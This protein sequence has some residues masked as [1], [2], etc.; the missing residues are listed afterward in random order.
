MTTIKERKDI[1]ITDTWNLNDIFES[2]DLFHENFKKV[3]S[4]IPSFA[5]YVGKLTS[6]CELLYDF[7]SEQDELA[8]TMN[9]LYLYAHMH[10]HEDGNVSLY[11]DLSTKTETLSIEFYSAISFANPELS[12]LTE[13]MILDFIKENPKLSVYKRY[14]FEILR[15]KKHILNASTENLLAKV[16]EIASSPSQIF[17]MLDNVDINFGTVKNDDGVEVPL[18]HGNY[19]S[20]LESKTRSVRESAFKTLYK[21]YSSYKNTLATTFSS[22]VK[23]YLL[24]SNVRGFETPLHYALHENNIPISVYNN[25]IDTVHEHLNL[26]YD[27]VALR[28]NHLMLDEL[29]MYDLFVPMAKNF[30]KKISYD[31]ACELVLKSL[32]PLG[33]EYTDIAKEAFTNRWVDKF[34]N[35]GKRS[36]AYSWSTYGIPHPY[37]LMNY[38]ENINSLFTLAHELGH[39]MHSYFSHKTQPFIYSDY[40]IF[41]AEV[42]STVNESLLMQYL[43]KTTE[44]PT[45][46]RYLISYFMDQFRSTLYRQTMFAEFEKEVHLFAKEG[47][48][49]TASY[50]CDKYYSLVQK[51][52]G[53]HLC[54]DEDIKYEWSRIPHFYNPFYVYQYATGFSAAI[55]LSDRIL[56]EC[57]QAVKDY[58]TFLSSGSSKDPIDLLK[59]AGVDMSTKEPIEKAL[60]VFSTLISSF[61]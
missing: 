61:N 7:L 21:T 43:L 52:H 36:G 17:A 32:A 2:I 50:L 33:K 55:A 57:D 60:A 56:N 10:L 28:K 59:D 46:K 23:Q 30:D 35:M 45:F 27:Y 3:Q 44:D 24:F 26:M 37:I 22:N 40:C 51:Y 34:E 19:I 25:L 20:F 13:N 14:L 54:V 48:V 11:Q 9:Q 38:V 5:K 49:L 42:A 1:P 39:A 12:A 47:G 53:D 6:S 29:H 58:I 18:T 8:I 15:Q 4:K 16:S 41:V 31:E